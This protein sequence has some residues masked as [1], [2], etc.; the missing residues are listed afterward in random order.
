MPECANAKLFEVL[1]GEAREDPL[2]DLVV[3]ECRLVFFEA[4]APQPDQNVHEGTQI[5]GCR[6][7]SCSPE[8]V[9]SSTSQLVCADGD[10]IRLT[11]EAKFAAA[12]KDASCPLA[13]YI[14]AMNA[15][16]FVLDDASL[17]RAAVEG[18]PETVIAAIYL[19]HERSV[20]E[21]AAKLTPDELE[22][23]IRLVGRCPSCYP[24][25]TL[26]ALKGK[27]AALSTPPT[28][29]PLNAKANEE[30]PARPRSQHRRPPP[31]PEARQGTAEWPKRPNA[32]PKPT[33]FRG[34]PARERSGKAA[35][36]GTLGGTAAETARRRLTV[37]DLVKAGLS[38]RMIA[39]ATDISHKRNLDEGAQRGQTTG[40]LAPETR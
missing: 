13:G 14:P 9:S 23:V 34:P 27:R 26:D 38:I 3:A 36:A 33:G 29:V 12:L 40:R 6:T 1:G 15:F 39:G 19:L 20:G 4:K 31:R 5:Q 22:H 18:V 17:R 21:V 32:A 25:G 30:A 11:P 16:G 37:E 28:S 35:R 8:R 24:L 10:K 7:S 2:V